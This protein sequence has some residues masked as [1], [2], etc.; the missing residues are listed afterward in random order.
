[1]SEFINNRAHKQEKLKELIKKLHDGA[2]VDDVKA[3]FDALTINV[4]PTEIAEMEQALVNEGMPVSE[5]QR[6]CDVHATVFRGSIEEI[7]RKDGFSLDDFN[8]GHPIHTF[9]KENRKI[10]ALIEF[11]ILRTLSDFEENPTPDT[12]KTLKDSMVKLLTID[13]HYKRK[14]NLIFPFMEKHDITAPPQVMWGVDDEI[15]DKIKFVI[16]HL[17]Q[18]S[19]DKPLVDEKIKDAVNSVNEMI[20]KEEEIMFPMILDKFSLQEWME[21]EKASEEIGFTLI[22]DVQRWQP[23]IESIE[24]L[25]PKTSTVDASPQ[26][27]SHLDMNEDIIVN[28]IKKDSHTYIPFD[29]GG[30]TAIEV[31]AILNTVPVDMTF[32]GADDK[33]KY[34]TQGKE[35]IFDRPLTIIGREVKNCHPP[36]SMHVVE[37]IVEDLKSGKKDNEDF[38]IRLGDQFVYIR[39]FAVRSKEGEFLGTLEV[40]QNIKPITELEGEKRLMSE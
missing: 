11:D 30:L 38:W 21:I 31:N 18:E 33:V 8:E 1:M 5:I 15:R 24:V 36:K 4:S 9:R 23:V 19:V 40:S 29:A 13:K 16:E 6:L 2:T 28:R 10:E 26:Q 25:K 14:E 34:F 32:V 39:Y 17:N 12:Q 22:S 20:F 7:H 35:R 37:K 3:E 27:M